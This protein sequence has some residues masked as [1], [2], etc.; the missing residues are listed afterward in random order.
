MKRCS[1]LLIIRKTQIKTTM[2]Y[3][4]TSIR[5][6]F[7]KKTIN[8][9]SWQGFGEKGT[10]IHHWWEWKSVQ[11][12]WKTVWRSIKSLKIE[13]KNRSS[14]ST[15]GYISEENENSNWKWCWHPKVHS[16][17]I[18]NSHDMEATGGS[19]SKASVYNAGDPDSIP[20]SGRSPGEGNGNPLQYYCLENPMEGG[21]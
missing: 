3:H 13:P 4:L 16:S 12:L 17:I 1:T 19:D 15:L 5:M 11:P 6:T 21:A 2:R 7:I 8:N 18:Y 20:G 9:K 10:P 14:N